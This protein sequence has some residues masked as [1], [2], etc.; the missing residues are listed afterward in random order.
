MCVAVHTASEDAFERLAAAVRDAAKL[1]C[2]LTSA[3]HD[4]STQSLWPFLSICT[5]LL[6]DRLLECLRRLLIDLTAGARTCYYSPALLE[7]PATTHRKRP[8]AAKRGER[9][10]MFPLRLRNCRVIRADDSPEPTHYDEYRREEP[11]DPAARAEALAARA[12]RSFVAP[13]TLPPSAGPFAVGDRVNARCERMRT[14]NSLKWFSGVVERKRGNKY[15][16]LYDDGDR[17][18]GLPATFVRKEGPADGLIIK[19]SD[20]GEDGDG[21]GPVVELQVLNTE[22]RWQPARSLYEYVQQNVVEICSVWDEQ[23]PADAPEPSDDDWAPPKWH[24]ASELYERHLHRCEPGDIASLLYRISPYFAGYIVKQ[25]RAK[26]LGIRYFRVAAQRARVPVEII[27]HIE[28]FAGLLPAKDSVPCRRDQLPAFMQRLVEQYMDDASDSHWWQAR[29]S[30]SIEVRGTTVWTG[31]FGGS[32]S[33]DEWT[34]MPRRLLAQYQEVPASLN[35]RIAD[36]DH[37]Q[38]PEDAIDEIDAGPGYKTFLMPGEDPGDEYV[39]LTLDWF[40]KRPWDHY[41]QV[42]HAWPPG[43]SIE[44]D[45][46]PREY[47]NHG[48]I[49]NDGFAMATDE[50]RKKGYA[51]QRSCKNAGR[52]LGYS[53]FEYVDSDDCKRHRLLEERGDVPA[54]RLRPRG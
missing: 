29:V 24:T 3:L 14:S 12:A 6:S 43:C 48:Q 20:Q 18:S 50:R 23:N 5:R 47:R 44:D 26:V 52:V 49:S 10:K 35:E 21:E 53:N 22:G 32:H 54:S 34:L 16:V 31:W 19:S 8:D 27:K 38:M 46:P 11:I 28:T 51:Y 15:D 36:W 41:L 45:V 39:E 40:N 1:S 42:E 13:W 25:R 30:S 33:C 17:E 7:P 9:A 37:G 2:G 4:A